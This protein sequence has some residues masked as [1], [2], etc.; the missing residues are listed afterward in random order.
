MLEGL[1]REAHLAAMLGKSLVCPYLCPEAL[2]AAR[3]FSATEMIG[4]QGNK[5]PLRHLATDL[6]LSAAQAPKKAAQYG[7]GII[8]AMKR[9]AAKEGL[10]LDRWVREAER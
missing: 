9:M 10:G 6:G 1:P 5:L 7:S 2:R 8:A 4:P 3:R